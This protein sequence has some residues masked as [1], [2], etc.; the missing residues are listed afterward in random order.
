MSSQYT[1]KSK[2]DDKLKVILNTDLNYFKKILLKNEAYIAGGFLLS[3]ITNLYETS[4][5]DIYINEINFNRFIKDLK[6]LN[7]FKFNIYSDPNPPIWGMDDFYHNTTVKSKYY[8]SVETRRNIGNEIYCSSE[9]SD[10]DIGNHK[11]PHWK[12]KKPKLC[13]IVIASEYDLSF[14]KKN[15]IKFKIEVFI[16][17]FKCDIMILN[18]KRKVLDVVS[19]FDLTFCQLW[20]NGSKFS[21]THLK[22]ISNKIGYLNPDYLE[23]LIKNNYFILNR[24]EKYKKRGFDIYNVAGDISNIDI[25][26]FHL[27]SYNKYEI[28]DIEKFLVKIYIDLIKKRFNLLLSLLKNN[29]ISSNNKY[30]YNIV[31]I[32]NKITTFERKVLYGAVN[33]LEIFSNAEYILIENNKKEAY[34]KLECKNRCYLDFELNKIRNLN[35]NQSEIIYETLL[36][37]IN[38]FTNFTFNEL[39]SNTYLYFGISIIKSLKLI[40]NYFVAIYDDYFKNDITIQKILMT[41]AEYLKKKE[42]F[43]YICDTLKD[44]T[45]KVS[46]DEEDIDEELNQINLLTDDINNKYNLTCINELDQI[47]VDQNRIINLKGDD[48]INM[49]YDINIRDY[50]KKNEDNMCFI[51][52]VD[53]ENGNI[54]YYPYLITRTDLM[55]FLLDKNSC[56]FYK[57]NRPDSIADI[58]RANLYIKIP[59]ELIM[60]VYYSDLCYILK[61]KLQI[62]F[63]KYLRNIKHS[64]SHDLVYPNEPGSQPNFV[65]SKHCQEGSDIYTYTAY[66]ARNLTLRAKSISKSKSKEF[67]LKVNNINIVNKNKLKSTKSLS[68]KKK[69]K[70]VS[71]TDKS[72]AKSL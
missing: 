72:K 45:K 32:P 2:I 70:S 66:Q 19:N 57:C 6:K 4:D 33:E 50:I 25:S 43:K 53:D 26:K 18:K 35:I 11:A 27:S 71:K 17:N 21:G 54:N 31:S 12:D 61:N 47:D 65:S 69:S 55:R 3:A 30:V 29:Y 23:S 36:N 14:F 51:N 62:V 38:S 22:D 37:Y 15:G 20:Y 16:N 39:I 67:T 42:R 34:D 48:V 64:V 60:W 44:I 63:F 58:D 49:E 5:I 59:F 13:N 10:L 24:I 46:H 1:Y 8:Y 56:W 68:P 40:R 52:I 28:E 7:N 9:N 41:T